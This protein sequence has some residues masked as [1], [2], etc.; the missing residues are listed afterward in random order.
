MLDG[1]ELLN[2]AADRLRR[3]AGQAR[4]AHRGQHVLNVVFALERNG[5]KEQ[6]GL[7]SRALRGA[8]QTTWPSSTHAPCSTGCSRENQ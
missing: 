5:A 7:G 4:S 2:G 6:D 3:R 8:E 1:L